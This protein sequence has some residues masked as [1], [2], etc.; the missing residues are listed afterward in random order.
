MEALTSSG[1]PAEALELEITENIA[2]QHDDP[3]LT[4]LSDLRAL[5]VGIAFDD[6][7][8]GFAS[9]SMLKR[10]PLTRLKLDRSF[11]QDLQTDQ[12]D[13]AIVEAVLV[14]GHSLGLQIIAEGIETSDQANLLTMMRCDEGQGFLYSKPMPAPMFERL[15]ATEQTDLATGEGEL[16]WPAVA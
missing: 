6:F 3:T 7:G 15:L 16:V 13:A 9:L 12:H 10:F 5:G 14:M 8:T 4:C 11:V 2:L 1:L